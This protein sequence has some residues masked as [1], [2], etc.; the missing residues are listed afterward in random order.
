M[1]KFVNTALDV[2]ANFK[3]I[4]R[5]EFPFRTKKT[6]T[7]AGATADEWGND[8]G[9]LDGGVMF[10]VTGLVMV[11]MLAACTT[12]LTGATATLS[13]GITGDTAIFLPVETAT[14][15]DAG[16]VWLNDAGNATYGIVG[17]EAAAADNF[18]EYI[19]NGNDIIM[20]IATADVET[21]VLDFYVLWQPISDDANLVDS[22]N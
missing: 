2:D 12:L 22:G 21:G 1:S 20:T 13:V 6:I 14:E 5:G 11:K 19:L 16:Q 17:E 15:I 7:F 8:G 4:Y 18:P 10:T 3:P 9:A